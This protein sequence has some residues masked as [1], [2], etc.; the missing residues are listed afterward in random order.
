[1]PEHLARRVGVDFIAREHLQ[2]RGEAGGSH[3]GC[4]QLLP[5]LPD[6]GEQL[7]RQPVHR[8][9]RRDP[10]PRQGLEEDREF[11]IGTQE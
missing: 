11:R 7:R 4:A 8:R 2:Q 10:F 1:M 6:G 9:A 5:P 3:G